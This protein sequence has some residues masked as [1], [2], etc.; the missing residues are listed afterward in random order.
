MAVT[1]GKSVLR[2]IRFLASAN[3]EAYR[4]SRQWPGQVYFPWHPLSVYLAEGKLYHFEL[5]ICDRIA[6]GIP[7]DQPTSRRTCRL[8]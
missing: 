8:E 5:G 3:E 7:M 6:A 1:I 4:F 2:P